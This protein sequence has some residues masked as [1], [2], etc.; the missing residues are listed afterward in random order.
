MPIVYF[1]HSNGKNVNYFY[2][3]PFLSS[4]MVSGKEISDRKA[5]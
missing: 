4:N 2:F 3:F 5:F 1:A